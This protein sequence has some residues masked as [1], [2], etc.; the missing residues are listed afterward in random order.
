MISADKIGAL[1][2][3]EFAAADLVT[4]TLPRGTR[5]GRI[6][7]DRYPDPLGFGKTSSR[8]SDPRHEYGVA[9]LGSTLQVCFI[10]AYLRDQKN[11]RV[12]DFLI[13]ERDISSRRFVDIDVIDP[14]TLVELRG[15]AAIAMGIPSDVVGRSTH[16]LSQQWSRAIYDH[17][18]R[19][20]G[21]LYPSR[22]TQEN[23]IAVFDRAIPK[24]APKGNRLLTEANGLA[25]V[26]R[27]LRVA[28]G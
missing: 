6:Y 21:I 8:F 14:L 19:P 10:E 16:E 4:E 23:N 22:F 15:P 2:P 3:P 28:I 7:L 18:R 13:S 12:G 5:F 20:D 11:G 26:L 17:P 24:L 25:P 9:Y 27:T 1:P